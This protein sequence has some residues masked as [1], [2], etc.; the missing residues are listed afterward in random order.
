MHS[1]MRRWPSV[2]EVKKHYGPKRVFEENASWLAYFVYRPVSFWV[3]PPFIWVG[4]SPNQVT[5]LSLGVMWGGIACLVIGG[6]VNTLIGVGLYFVGVILDYVDGNI[7]RFYGTGSHFGKFLDGISDTLARA[8]LYL[9]VALGMFLRSEPTLLDDLSDP[10]LG[11]GLLLLTAA[12]AEIFFC[13][14]MVLIWRYRAATSELLLQHTGRPDRGGPAQEWQEDTSQ[15][16]DY[17]GLLGRLNR[18][19]MWLEKRLVDVAD[20]TLIMLAVFRAL[21]AFILWAVFAEAVMLSI[22][23]ARVVWQARRKLTALRPY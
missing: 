11:G 8:F 23:L 4:L 18:A 12:I 19:L 22:T 21:D 9:A 2:P 13:L 6:Y 10:T 20:V 14:R 17:L 3:T 15:A 5:L 7:A 16:P 1:S